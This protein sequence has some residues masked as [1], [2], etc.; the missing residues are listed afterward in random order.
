MLEKIFENSLKNKFF[1][2]YFY[3][4]N[5][6]AYLRHECQIFIAVS[7]NPS[8]TPLFLL[9]FSCSRL[10]SENDARLTI[11]Y[12]DTPILCYFSADK[13]NKRTLLLHCLSSIFSDV[14]W[15][16]IARI[17]EGIIEFNR[18]SI[19]STIR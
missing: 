19:Y 3:I 4:K 9:S 12:R 6:G 10:S 16:S 8:D 2:R 14:L 5:Y 1:D 13:L 17:E 15:F 11:Q 7:W 18:E